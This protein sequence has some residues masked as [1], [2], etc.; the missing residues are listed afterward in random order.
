MHICD[1][2]PFGVYPPRGGGHSRIHSLNLQA[3]QRGHTVFLFSQGIR[4]FELEFPLKSWTT[5]INEGYTEYRYVSML[6]LAAAFFTGSAG[7]PPLFAGDVLGIMR[8]SILRRE[9]LKSD[10]VKVEHPWQV[11]YVKSIAGDLPVVVVEA[12]VECDLLQQTLNRRVAYSEYLYRKAVDKEQSALS[13]ADAVVVTSSQDKETIKQE[14]DIKGEVHVIPNG[15]DVSLIHPVSTP[16]RQRE[17]ERLG[18]SSRKVVLFTG[19]GHPP[20]REAVQ[21]I[22]KMARELPDVLFVVAGR[23]GDFFTSKRNVLF[24]GY[25][26]DIT[27][28][29]GAA[30]IAVNPVTSGSGTNLKML[31]YMA[32]GLPVVS[33]VTGVRGLQV[34]PGVHALIRGLGEFSSA[35]STILEDDDLRETLSKNGRTLVEE[36]YDWKKIGGRELDILHQLM[37]S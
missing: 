11:D 6:S 18:F 16:E 21:H 17:K 26:E 1:I 4:K 12:N 10:V 5:Q 14:F 22:V 15:V 7:A 32:A 30:D 8:P 29:L 31:E 13:L 20:N 25:V 3:S 24:T 2:A 34:E 9:V 19:S 27:P 23:V 37:R 36:T 28:F 33:T 35:F